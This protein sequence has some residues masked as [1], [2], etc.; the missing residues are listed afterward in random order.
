MSKTG[1][2]NRKDGRKRVARNVSLREDVAAVLDGESERRRQTV[3]AIVE[4]LLVTLMTKGCGGECPTCAMSLRQGVR[5]DCRKAE[6][7]VFP[8]AGE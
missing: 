6:C 8:M 5:V 1:Y 7:P 4:G 3:S 2:G